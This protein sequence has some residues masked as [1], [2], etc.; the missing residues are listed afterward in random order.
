VEIPT[1]FPLL[2][3]H[4]C[5]QDWLSPGQELENHLP[6]YCNTRKTDC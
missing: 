1:L 5:Q 3:Y 4:C 6:S 2:K